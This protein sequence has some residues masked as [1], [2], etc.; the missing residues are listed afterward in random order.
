MDVFDEEI[1]KFWRCLSEA[2]VRYIM[3]GD[4]ASNLNGYKTF[5][6][7]LG[8]WIE[9]TAENRNNIRIDSFYRRV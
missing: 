2:D 3:V 9:D 6:E 5:T 4:Y 7:V 8:I 1:I